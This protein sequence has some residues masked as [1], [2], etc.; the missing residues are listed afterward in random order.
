VTGRGVV[1]TGGGTGIGRAA[2]RAFADEGDDVLIVGRTEDTLKEAASGYPGIRSLVADVSAPDAPETIVDTALELFGRIDVLVNNAAFIRAGKLGELDHAETEAQ[3]AI[4]LLAPIYLTQQALPAL[5]ETRGVVVNISSSVASG[6]RG[7]P[8]AGVYGAAKS[9]LDYL[10]RTW[11][12]ELGAQGIR[13][14]GLSPGLIETGVHLRMAQTEEQHEKFVN[15]LLP[16]IPLGR[17]GEPEEIARWIVHVAH[18]DAA[19]LTG[20]VLPLDGG[21]SVT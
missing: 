8:T 2:A 9:G 5:I 21:L 15:W 14:V 3:V 1:I 6:Q 12:A 17:A 7:W 10:T 16:Q 20:V 18:P 19:Y 11:A 4:N 13:V